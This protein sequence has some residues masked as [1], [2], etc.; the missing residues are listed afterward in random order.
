VPVDAG[1]FLGF[2]VVLHGSSSICAPASRITEFFLNW[3]RGS[4]RGGRLLGAGGCCFVPA[5]AQ[6]RGRFGIGDA[7]GCSSSVC[8]VLAVKQHLWEGERA[9]GGRTLPQAVPAPGR[10]V[11]VSA[12]LLPRSSSPCNSI[13]AGFKTL[14]RFWAGLCQPSRRVGLH[15]G[16]VPARAW[17]EGMMDGAVSVFGVS[18]VGSSMRVGR[19]WA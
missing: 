8:S 18:L 15:P 1:G 12:A 11:A 19:M 17:D 7:L 6:G 9:A 14:P 4:R 2:T 3:I 5:C 13:A 16:Q 10:A